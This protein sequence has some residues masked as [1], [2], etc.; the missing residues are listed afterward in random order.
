MITDTM[1]GRSVCGLGPDEV[2]VA[3]MD[4]DHPQDRHQLRANLT[5]CE[6]DIDGNLDCRSQRLRP[7][8]LFA[9]LR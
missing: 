8:Y 3:L 5:H 7:N 1:I 4:V 2:Q 6:A 9:R